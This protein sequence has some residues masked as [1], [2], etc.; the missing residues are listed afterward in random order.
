MDRRGHIDD[1]ELD[2]P[3]V[4]RGWE[5]KDVSGAV[6]GSFPSELMYQWRL[7]GRLRG[8]QLVREVGTVTWTQVA[9]RE[10]V[11]RQRAFAR[12]AWKLFGQEEPL[13]W[14]YKDPS[15][16]AHGPFPGQK[17]WEWFEGG[18]LYKGLPVYALESVSSVGEV[19]FAPLAKLIEAQLLDNSQ[20]PIGLLAYITAGEN[21]AATPTS[22]EENN[23]AF[24]SG[25][26]KPR[27]DVEQEGE[28]EA[29]EGLSLQN[30]SLAE[31]A[32]YAFHVFRPNRS[33][34]HEWC[35]RSQLGVYGPYKWQQM[36]CWFAEGKLPET[37]EVCGMEV[38]PEDEQEEGGCRTDRMQ[39]STL[40]EELL[41]EMK[42]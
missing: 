22:S 18:T 24:T 17:M 3:L 16:T 33:A 12:V 20:T 32:K 26:C 11:L 35:F 39:F 36:Y 15:G 40:G 9:S 27:G 10:K 37:L 23:T 2:N 4:E 25:A 28:A 1:E 7:K 21:R 14:F 19:R 13:L 42:R 8:H 31:L 30:Y 29:E 38:V 5:Y 34:E 41:K 6:R